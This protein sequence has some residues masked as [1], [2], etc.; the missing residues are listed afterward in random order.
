MA[1]AF[2]YLYRD[3][4]NYKA[5]GRVVFAGECDS[6]LVARLE[7]ALYD[8]DAFIA[9]Q[10][11]VPEVFLWD[12]GGFAVSDDDHCW[13]GSGG[14]SASAEE[15]DDGAG[16]TFGAFVAEVEAANRAGCEEFDPGEEG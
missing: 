11:R 5:H 6:G 7:A 15:P 9:R 14:V 2:D 12:G 10:V 1:V 13:H 4:S 3:G 8:G 16:R